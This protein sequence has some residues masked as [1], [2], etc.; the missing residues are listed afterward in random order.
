MGRYMTFAR[1]FLILSIINFVR[2]A[3]LAVRQ[4]DESST[5]QRP[6]RAFSAPSP[7]SPN[8]SPSPSVP[9][10]SLADDSWPSYLP[11]KNELSA[12]P[13]AHDSWPSYLPSK[14]ELLA[15]PVAHDSWPSYLPSKSELSAN[16]VP[17]DSW[18][19][20]LPSKSELSA[21]PVPDGSR[22]SQL[23]STSA[24][25]HQSTDGH[26]SPSPEPLNLESGPAD[27]L[28]KILKGKLRRRAMAPVAAV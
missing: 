26:P 18:P 19:G 3:P 10:K 9:D 28:D 1:I 22:P 6:K 8:Y 12:N 23:P 27:F 17:H 5:S 25:P 15:N 21:N 2:A 4:E 16:P 14:N 13:V 7:G 20:Y 11:S 24:G